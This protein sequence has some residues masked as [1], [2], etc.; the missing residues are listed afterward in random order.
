MGLRQKKYVWACLVDSLSIQLTIGVVLGL[1]STSLLPKY[2][3]PPPRESD[4]PPPGHVMTR[5]VRPSGSAL[6]KGH[7]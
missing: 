5:T 1:P 7:G 2:R 6:V 3:L 4:T